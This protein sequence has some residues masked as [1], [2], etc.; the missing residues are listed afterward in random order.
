LE[1]IFL[2]DFK[3]AFKDKFAN[4]LFDE[5]MKKHTTFKIGGNADVFLAPENIEEVILSID[6][7]KKFE[8]P[9][10]I[11]GNG[12]N[13]LVGDGGFSGVI[14]QIFKNMGNIEVCGNVIKAEG[15]ALLSSVSKKALTA[16]LFGLE[17]ASGIPGTVGGAVCM[18]AGAYGGEMKDVISK[19][20]VLKNGSIFELSNDEA[21]F[22]YRNSRIL[23]EGAIV[24]GTE[25]I[26]Q[27]G[28]A[29]EIKEKMLEFNRLRSEK[30]PLE[31]PSAGSTFK[32]P[33]G[34]FAGKL[35][36]DSG[37]K[38]YSVGGAAVSEKHC[39]FVVNKGNATAKDVLTLIEDVKKIVNDKFG[40]M[41]EPEIR[42]IGNF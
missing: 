38:G 30:Q 35:I 7:C 9:F 27:K 10:Y 13:L 23:K 16:E 25:I 32:R 14:I 37:L 20:T 6:L 41:L 24:L 36:M 1:L 33:E 8:L 2:L 34:Y 19:V 18:N 31:F 12:S 17:F 42:L 21:G 22:Q 26:L 5:P 3:N 28:N 4:V 15:G 40:V 11:I 29:D 39:G